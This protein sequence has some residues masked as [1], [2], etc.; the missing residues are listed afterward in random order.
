MNQPHGTQVHHR[1]TPT[2]GGDIQVPSVRL[3]DVLEQITL[4]KMDVEGFEPH[5]LRGASELIDRCRPRMAI[6]TCYHQALDLL[7]IVGVADA[8]YPGTKLRLRHYSM[9][10]YG[11]IL[12]VSEAI[13]HAATIDRGRSSSQAPRLSLA[14]RSAA[15]HR[16]RPRPAVELGAASPV[17]APLSTGRRPDRAT[18]TVN[19]RLNTLCSASWTLRSPL[20][21]RL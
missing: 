21:P 16:L 1:G 8:I 5:V 20:P 9:Y 13:G 17:A 11:T 19:L 12:Y 4:L 6:I 2:E 10:F 3:D 14:Q 15:G 18:P 7:D